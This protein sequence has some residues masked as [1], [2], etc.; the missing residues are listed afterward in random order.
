[1]RKDELMRKSVSSSIVWDPSLPEGGMKVRSLDVWDEGEERRR[2]EEQRLG[3]VGCSPFPAVFAENS[4][5][6]G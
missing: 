6:S 2:G 1:M 5:H 4:A 3:I